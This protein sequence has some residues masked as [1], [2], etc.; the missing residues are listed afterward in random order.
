[1]D[2][3]LTP[4][5]SLASGKDDLKTKA[6]VRDGRDSDCQRMYVLPVIVLMPICKLFPDPAFKVRDIAG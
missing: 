2:V 5:I 4:V 6:P 1:M 3:W